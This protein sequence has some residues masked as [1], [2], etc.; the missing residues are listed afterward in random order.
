MLLMSPLALND[1]APFACSTRESVMEYTRVQGGTHIAV[2]VITTAE[3][4]LCFGH[5][6]SF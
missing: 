4:S 3:V 1:M 6:T 2:G 5:K